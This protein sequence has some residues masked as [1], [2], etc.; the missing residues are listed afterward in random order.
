[1]SV[2][3]DLFQVATGLNTYNDHPAIRALC[4]LD[5]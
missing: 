1:M 3:A 2:G 4:K 5:V